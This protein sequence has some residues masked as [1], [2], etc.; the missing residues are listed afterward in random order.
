MKYPDYNSRQSLSLNTP[1]E[2]P[3]DGWVQTVMTNYGSQFRVLLYINGAEAAYNHYQGSGNT[4]M[5]P[6]KAGD[7]VRCDSQ[8]SGGSGF[9]FYFPVR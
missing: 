9:L 7:V 2:I 8:Y 6:V 4:E 1:H 5:I 3:N